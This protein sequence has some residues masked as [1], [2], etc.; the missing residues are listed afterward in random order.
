MAEHLLIFEDGGEYCR[1]L[2]QGKREPLLRSSIAS[3]L[4]KGVQKL[5]DGVKMFFLLQFRKTTK[6][7]EIEKLSKETVGGYSKL[8]ASLRGSLEY[9]LHEMFNFL[10]VEIVLDSLLST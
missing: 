8:L 3:L 10:V 2:L 9:K 7:N 1:Y 5:C 4:D 6:P